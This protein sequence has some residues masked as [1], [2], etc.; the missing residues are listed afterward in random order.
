MLFA[1]SSTAQAQ[2]LNDRLIGKKD[3]DKDRLLVQ[4]Q[5]LVY[6]SKNEV[7]TANGSARS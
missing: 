3:G 1:H 2:T 4:A 5:E 6:D 7:V